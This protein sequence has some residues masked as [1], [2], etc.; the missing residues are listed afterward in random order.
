MLAKFITASAIGLLALSSF[1]QKQDGNAEK[2][3]VVHFATSCNLPAQKEFDRAVAL[4][5]SFQFSSAIQGFRAALTNDPACGIADWGISLSQWSNPFA[6]GMKD[7][8]QLEA[9]RS[10]AARGIATGAKTEREG[11][12]LLAVANLYRD[13]ETTSQQARMIAYR[14]AMAELAKRYP[15][16]DEAKIFY[17]LA[18]VATEEPTDKSYAARLQAGAILEKLFREEPNHPGLAHY[19]IHTY[20]VPA[21]AE[22]ALPAAQRYSKIAPD[23]PH[24]LHMPSHTFTRV[25]YW[26]DSIDSNLA[27]AAV[28]HRQGQTAEE[29]HATDYMEYAYLQTG[30]DNS[31]RQVVASLQD[32]AGRFDPKMIVSGAAGPSA[33]Y[34]ALAAIPARY[35][36]ERQDWNQA[37]ELQPQN[38]PFPYTEAMT[39]FAR[40][41]GAAHLHDGAQV[42]ASLA[43]LENLHSRLEKAGEHYWAGQVEIER[44][45]VNAWKLLMEGRSAMAL[46]TMNSAVALEDGTEK[47]AVSP[48]PL[49][50]ARELLGEMLL[51]MD[52]PKQA[53]EQFVLTLK[54]EPNRFRT[55]YGAGRAAQLSGNHGA[56]RT[57]F[58]ELIKQCSRADKPGRAEISAASKALAEN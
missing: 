33:A 45:E 14:N 23:A 55:L 26:Q 18:L 58:A 38:T 41:M 5:H 57:Y 25:G 47:S 50:P 15:G 30:Q 35:A 24:A 52:Q 32:I 12:Y 46:S 51:D 43:A 11:A 36:L 9:G 8:N 13:F 3:G 6:V 39:W 27:A 1:A 16:D 31:A 19:I 17:A 40:G 21:L 48:G 29:L 20:D 37:L 54:K 10:F 7:K 42:R 44:L 34:F 56:S 49:A 53:L 28:S 2:L 4:L 22:R